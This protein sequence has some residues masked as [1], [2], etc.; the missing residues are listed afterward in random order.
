MKKL[1]LSVKAKAELIDWKATAR[2]HWTWIKAPLVYGC[3]GGLLLV[4]AIMAALLKM[5][6]FDNIGFTTAESAI[7]NLV[8]IKIE[9]ALFCFFCTAVIY[10]IGNSYPDLVYRNDQPAEN[11]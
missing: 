8:A 2:L 6:M 11:R 7:G 4:D 10:A 1:F 3:I 9:F 5:D